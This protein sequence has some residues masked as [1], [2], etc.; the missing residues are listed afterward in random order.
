ML[1]NPVLTGAA[2]HDASGS[3]A[4]GEPNGMN[5]VFVV[6]LEP[7]GHALLQTIGGDEKY[8]FL[9]LFNYE[10]VVRPPD[11]QYPSLDRL[12]EDACERF[13]QFEGPVHGIMG[14][15]D[16]PTSA[17]VPLVA[18]RMGMPGPDLGALAR[19][20][21][22]YW[23][24]I[25]Q[26]K[27]VPDYV[28]RFQAV[29]PFA[30]DAV[31]S[32]HLA[33]PFWIKP[34]KAHSSFLGFHIDSPDKLRARLETI[35]AQIG[36][37]GEPFNEF[38]AHVDVPEDIRG[39]GGCHCIAEELVSS[40]HQCTLEGYACQGTVEI[41][42]IIDS[43]RTGKHD[44]CFSRYQ[45]P[46]AL[47]TTVQAR[48]EAASRKLV[49]HLEYDNAAFNVEFFWNPEDD[50]LHLLEINARIS[51]SHSP[52]FLMVDGTTNQKISLDLALGRTPHF[53][54]RSGGHNVAAKF[55]VRYFNDGVLTHVPTDDDISR[56]QET[57][58]ES[59]VRRLAPQG[60][61]LSDLNLQ[62]S[63]SYEVAE[64]FLGANSERELLKK[65]HHALEVLDFQV[66]PTGLEP[67]P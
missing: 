42:G 62:D 22:K 20:E 1:S 51:R 34:V 31:A 59:W 37:M 19:C 53:P 29:D 52:L 32:I 38:L 11:A 46:S 61:R 4:A 25:E 26:Q 50:R 10:E 45:Y 30:D 44:S 33:Y 63:Y 5:N 35:R 55:M 36:L 3:P 17:L 39:V 2:A 12:V 41:Y 49:H 56:L 47:P 13:N 40:G 43:L 64:I 28:P 27:I 15:W 48:M 8:R 67:S 6:G 65:Y 66:R 57:C 23:S 9:E 21:H 16:F 18:T 24:R 14:Y 60:T 7:F 54:H 58:P